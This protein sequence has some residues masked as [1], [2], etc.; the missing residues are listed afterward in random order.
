[1]AKTGGIL[2]FAVLMLL[3]VSFAGATDINACQQINISDTYNLTTNVS[4][5]G[6]C[7]DIAVA[8]VILDC[9]SFDNYL[10]GAGG[11]AEI[12]INANLS[13]SNITIRN[14]N[15]TS[16]QWAV[17]FNGITNSRIENTLYQGCGSI[18]VQLINN[19]NYNILDGIYANTPVPLLSIA[20]SDFNIIKNIDN[21]QLAL[22]P[23]LTLYDSDTNML[24]N[25][26]N[27]VV[28]LTSSSSY[29]TIKKSS[30]SI[31]SSAVSH[32]IFDEINDARGSS[33]SS[34][35]NNTFKFSNFSNSI[36]NGLIISGNNN[37]IEHSLFQSNA[38][39]ALAISGNDNIVNN[40]T[41]KINNFGGLGIGGNNNRVINSFFLDDIEYV[42]GSNNLIYNN[43]FN[44]TNALISDNTT[45]IYLNTTKTAGANIYGGN[46]LGGNYWLDY[47]GEDT[48]G[49]GLGDTPFIIHPSY[50]IDFHPLVTANLTNN[51]L[52][53]L[54]SIEFS[55]VTNCVTPNTT[56]EFSVNTEDLENDTI[57]YAY[58]C[59]D[60]LPL[61]SFSANNSGSCYYSNLGENYIT[62]YV[63]DTLHEDYNSYSQYVRVT[64]EECVKA[65]PTC[66]PIPSKIVDLENENE[67][68]LPTVYM[69]LLSFV[70]MPLPAVITIVVIVAVVLLLGALG[71]IIKKIA[72]FGEG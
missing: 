4:F 14:C 11:G 40:V 72:Q 60:L 27:L 26:S 43:I 54:I 53:S 32:N 50:M 37:L 23:Q 58:R 45:I 31:V 63:N 18:C 64:T 68:L 30:V 38:I 24:E 70:T 71:T 21:Q 39:T 8:D 1:M 35:N 57:G 12:G 28:S 7:F 41:F 44:V 5:S 3:S 61:G 49:D 67:G 65:C 13:N 66:T 52:P 29:N 48:N 19:S 62:F 59:S 16:G 20:T 56:L 55:Q 36:V 6:T 42:I 46:Y 22:F 47:T 2:I 33:F 69:G 25:I 17:L 15:I 51:S 34:G 9:N 10:L